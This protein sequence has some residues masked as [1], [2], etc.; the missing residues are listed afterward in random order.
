MTSEL[1]EMRFLAAGVVPPTVFP[2]PR[3]IV[4]PVRMPRATVPEGSVPMKLPSIAL[5]SDTIL[6]APF[7]KRL[8]TSPRTVLPPT[9]MTR[10]STDAQPRLPAQLDQQHRV[11]A[12]GQRVG[13][14]PRLGVAVDDHRVGDRRQ[15]RGRADRLHA[16]AGDG[17]VDRVGAGI[18]VGVEDRLAQRA[19]PAVVGVRDDE[20]A[21]HGDLT[22]A[23]RSGTGAAGGP[24]G[25]VDAGQAPGE[26]AR[27]WINDHLATAAVSARPPHTETNGKF[28]L[29]LP[30]CPP[31]PRSRTGGPRDL[32]L[33]RAARCRHRA[34]APPLPVSRPPE[35]RSLRWPGLSP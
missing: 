15:G 6:I 7:T 14:G 9:V 18:G 22:E 23:A 17:E 21:D 8:I 30:T 20:R 12:D 33:R 34:A 13:A 32:P 27:S 35:I 28:L 11:V 25:Y 19:G 3:S 16:R 1:P 26:A 29:S 31:S 5:L 24:P 2:D 4:T 10:P